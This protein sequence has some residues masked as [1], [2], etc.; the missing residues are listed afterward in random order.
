MKEYCEKKKID[1][2]SKNR[3][4]KNNLVKVY[5]LALTVSFIFIAVKGFV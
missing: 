1:F 3:E 5:F 2:C 4:I